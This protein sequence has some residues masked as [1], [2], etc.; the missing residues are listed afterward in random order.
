MLGSTFGALDS[1]RGLIPSDYINHGLSRQN[2][3]FTDLMSCTWAV[4][5]VAYTDGEVSFHVRVRSSFCMDGNP[6]IGL[7]AKRYDDTGGDGLLQED[8]RRLPCGRRSAS[9]LQDED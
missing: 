6:W 9:L 3:R 2:D 7:L 1:V 4:S 8:G 5:A